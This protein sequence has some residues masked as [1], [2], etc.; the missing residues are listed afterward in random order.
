MGKCR[1]ERGIDFSLKKAYSFF[2][3]EKEMERNISYGKIKARIE[4]GEP[5]TIYITSD[6]LD[7]AST[8]AANGALRR[9]ARDGVLDQVMRGI[10]CKPK[11]NER[12]KRKIPPSPDDIARAVARNYGWTIIPSG[13]TALNML[14]LST[15]VPARWEYVSDG[16]YKEYDID[17]K[18][19][20]RFKHTANKEIT[21][22][23]YDA[24]L[25]IQA[26]KAMGK[27]NIDRK[28]IRKLSSG[29]TEGRKAEILKETQ[30]T[31]SWIYEVIRGICNE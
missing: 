23:S 29:M 24:A 13:N 6:F 12:L 30:Y 27:D 20:I 21:R 22:L 8:Y 10:Y 9:L 3:E 25:L 7:L 31:T 1:E 14:G 16:P 2:N 26:L 5:N 11:Y 18:T 4:E 19:S 17:D 28:D 15:Q